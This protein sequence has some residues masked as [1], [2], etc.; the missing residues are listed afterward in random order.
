MFGFFNKTRR[1]EDF[2]ARSVP[3]AIAAFGVQMK[4]LRDQYGYKRPLYSDFEPLL[5]VNWCYG[6]AIHNQNISINSIERLKN[7]VGIICIAD[8]TNEQKSDHSIGNKLYGDK[9]LLIQWL[10]AEFPRRYLEYNDAANE[11]KI[12][13]RDEK[14]TAGF[15]I[16]YIRI[17]S[18]YFIGSENS[19]NFIRQWSSS[20][21]ELFL[22]AK[23]RPFFEL[24]KARKELGLK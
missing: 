21:P 12:R 7:F 20:L 3:T 13:A 16:P 18:N 19:E 5:F 14:D 24:E 23:M 2:L 22:E 17:F 1:T 11:G 9:N 4:Y 10:A 6:H 15:V 8:S